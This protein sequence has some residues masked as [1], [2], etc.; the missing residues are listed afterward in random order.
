LLVPL[1]GFQLG[2]NGVQALRD[3]GELVPIQAQHPGPGLE[4]RHP[5][6]DVLA[7]LADV[8][9]EFPA[10]MRRQERARS[11]V[12]EFVEHGGTGGIENSHMI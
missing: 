2:E 3:T 7:L 8:L 9:D 10:G 5:S 6:P 1:Q 11:V 12:E 4:N